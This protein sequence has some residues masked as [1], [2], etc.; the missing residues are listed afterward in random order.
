MKKNTIPLF[1]VFM[2]PNAPEKVKKVLES[3]FIGEGKQVKVFEDRLKK[4]ISIVFQ[5]M[6]GLETM[7]KLIKMGYSQVTI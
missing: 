5:Y 7:K 1:K 3:G 4:Y 6:D 2:S